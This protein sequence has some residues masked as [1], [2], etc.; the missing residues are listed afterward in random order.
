[1]D[2]PYLNLGRTFYFLT[3]VLDGFSRSI[4]HYNNVRL[5]S[6]FG[7]VKPADKLAGRAEEINASRD[8]RLETARAKRKEKRNEQVAWQAA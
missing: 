8:R 1:M 5:H 4:V 7:Y 6:A 3:S 2:I